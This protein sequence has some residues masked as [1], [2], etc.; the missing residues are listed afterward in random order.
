M[1]IAI[2]EKW[3]TYVYNI[4]ISYYV[5]TGSLGDSLD[6]AREL[7]QQDYAMHNFG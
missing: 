4:V 3:P 7:L 6:L 1:I 5:Y 2:S